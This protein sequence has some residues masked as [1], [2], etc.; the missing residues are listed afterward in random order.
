MVSLSSANM[1]LSGICWGLLDLPVC[2]AER[3][4]GAE[5]VVGSSRSGHSGRQCRELPSSQG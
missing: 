3:V 1:N 4:G 2:E 5:S